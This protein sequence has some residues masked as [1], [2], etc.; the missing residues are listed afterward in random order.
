[1]RLQT[2]VVYLQSLASTL[3]LDTMTEIDFKS[4]SSHTHASQ[5]KKENKN[6]EE[7]APNEVLDETHR[8]AWRHHRVAMVRALWSRDAGLKTTTTTTAQSARRACEPHMTVFPP[9]RSL[10][11]RRV[12]G[13]QDRR[14][15][16]ARPDGHFTSS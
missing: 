3:Q 8:D 9:S 12:A 16:R 15:A 1:M 5:S 6:E 13:R 14:I 7:R 10:A 11:S 2:L 4:L